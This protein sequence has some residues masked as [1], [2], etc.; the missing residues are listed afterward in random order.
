MIYWEELID[1]YNNKYRTK[2]DMKSWLEHLYKKHKTVTGMAD[3]IGVSR[4]SVFK[5]LRIYEIQLR[6]KGCVN[7]ATKGI[8]KMGEQEVKKH[9]VKELADKFSVSE[10]H[11]RDVLR[12][13]GW[14]RKQ[15]TV[16]YI[17][18]RDQEQIKDLTGY[19][20]A[21]KYNIDKGYAYRMLRNHNIKH[22][23][24]RE[25]F[26]ERRCNDRLG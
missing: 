6:E 12:R 14:G 5:Q 20:I 15:Q 26:L 4:S 1:F 18:L 22:R 7:P 23:R 19:Q 24:I 13:Y 21:E 10:M 11:V 8:K 3:C 2:F 25:G 9:S 16:K 17:L